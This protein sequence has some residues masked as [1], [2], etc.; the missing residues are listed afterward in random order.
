MRFIIAAALVVLTAST[1]SFSARAELIIGLTSSG[2]ALTSFDST[3]PGTATTP[4]AITGL[5][6]ETLLDIDIRPATLELY[7]VGNLGNVYTIDPATGAATLRSALAAD[8][9]DATNPFAGLDP[10]SARF[11]ID[12][13]PVPDRLRIVS[14]GGQN[15]RVNVATGGVTTDGLLNGATSSAV[16]VAYTNPDVDPN[17]STQLFY[18]DDGIPGTLFNTTD[19]NAGATTN[20][21]SLLTNTSA[22]VGFDI[23]GSGL[24]FASLSDPT[25]GASSLYLVNLT[26]G[27]A[28]SLGG[29][30][31]A[32]GPLSLAGIA[33]QPVPEPGSLALL[34]LGIFGLSRF[35]R[36]R[37]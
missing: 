35:A 16:S 6:N 14:N 18:I 32:A 26:T 25:S 15:L 30:F 22:L 29:I 5:G 27:A 24:A 10:A 31:A 36:R 2:T 33:A 3:T 12:F 1:A 17:T 13:N 8:P 19:P 23:A 21:G 4:V 20:V 9:A 7:G 28:T 37:R 11:G 34:G